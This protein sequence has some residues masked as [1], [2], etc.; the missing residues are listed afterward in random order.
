MLPDESCSGALQEVCRRLGCT[1]KHRRHTRF[2]QLGRIAAR[3]ASDLPTSIPA[4]RLVSATRCL[5]TLPPHIPGSPQPLG[6]QAWLEMQARRTA[7]SSPTGTASPP[8]AWLQAGR[9]LPG[10]APPPAPSLGP[11]PPASLWRRP[12]PASLD[13]QLFW[14]AKQCLPHRGFAARN[15]P[16]TP[17]RRTATTD[18][19]E[20][21]TCPRRWCRAG[22]GGDGE[23]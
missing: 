20:S 15:R 16:G 7:A 18:Q 4:A 21:D 19:P 17:M 5:P 8:A 14:P 12:L 6:S 3:Y 13:S 9:P 10:P 2:F 1:R 23:R 22:R 11:C